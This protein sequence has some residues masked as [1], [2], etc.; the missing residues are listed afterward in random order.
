MGGTAAKPPAV[1]KPPTAGNPNSTPST[2]PVSIAPDGSIISEPAL[3]DVYI[4]LNV[5]GSILLCLGVALGVTVV[6]FFVKARNR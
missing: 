1:G 2:T 3:N 5:V 6:V 4:A